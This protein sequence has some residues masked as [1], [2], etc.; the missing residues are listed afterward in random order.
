M[1]SESHENKWQ[2]TPEHCSIFEMLG[3]KLNAFYNGKLERDQLGFGQ[4]TIHVKGAARTSMNTEKHI[5][6]K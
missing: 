3:A 5:Y 6:K 2:S 1:E 4:N